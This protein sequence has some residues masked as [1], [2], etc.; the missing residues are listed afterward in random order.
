MK[1]RRGLV[2]LAL[3]AGSADIAL[4]QE[5]TPQ[6]G[7][8]DRAPYFGVLGGYNILE[9]SDSSG[10]LGGFRTESDP[11]FAVGVRGGYQF[12]RFRG[13]LELTYRKNGADTFTNLGNLTRGL[14][15]RGATTEAD[16][17]IWSFAT[18]VNAI[19]DIPTDWRFTPYIGA[20]VG[21]VYLRHDGVGPR[22]VSVANGEDWDMAYQALAGVQFEVDPRMT[23]SLDY[24]YFS[25]LDP[26]IGDSYDT[27]YR[28]HTIMVGLTWRMAAPP[29]PPP[30][31]AEAP[32]PPPPP[33]QPELARS[34]LVF[35]DWNSAAVSPEG[36]GIIDEAARNAKTLAVTRLEVTGHAD[37][38]GGDAYNQKLSEK[39]GAAVKNALIS[40][41]VPENEISVVGKGESSPLVPT[42]DGVR[43]PQN[44][45]V[46]I[47]LP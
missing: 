46:E 39:R 18:M 44:R 14:P 35:F 8:P 38:S 15:D 42:A 32:P 29:P 1:T 20:G 9:D 12:E 17:N 3:L 10:R 41:G 4:A 22:G 16:G 43:E 40:L 47:V 37:R 26:R 45:R 30:R 27:D 2:A 25:A 34:Y 24:R 11:G 23:A 5:T 36:A 31:M 13:E 21:A 6:P 19:Y 7:R 33:A 28:N